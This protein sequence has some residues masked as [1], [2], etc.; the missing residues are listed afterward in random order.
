MKRGFA[1]S[2]CLAAATFAPVTMAGW[3][4]ADPGQVEESKQKPK[5][6]VGSDA[7]ALAV[8]QWVKGEPVEGF[9]PGHVYVVEFWATWCGPCIAGMPHLSELQ[10]RYKGKV[11]I[12][13][14][15]IWDDPKNVAPFM[16]KTGNERMRYTVAIEKKIE[17]QPVNRTGEMDQAWMKAAEQR[18]IPSAFVVDGKGK[19]AFVGH[20][21]WLDVPLE[22]VLAGTWDPE[23]GMKKVA[24][25]EEM[26]GAVYSSSSP[27]ERLAAFD[28]FEAEF[29]GVAH[30]SMFR[31]M[32]F[33]LLVECDKLDRAW[34]LGNEL[35]D[36]GMKTNDTQL[37]NS[38]AWTIVDPDKN[39]KERNLPL[40]LKAA[41]AAAAITE[42]NDAAILDTLARVYWWMGEKSKAVE[43]QR[44]AV[45]KAD[46]RMKG[47]I[48]AV[49]KEYEE[50]MKTDG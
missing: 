44:K 34:A 2:L 40:A 30:Q 47:Q 27:Q 11:T 24:R 28:A 41:K 1:L 19:I 10:E 9:K 50:A 18:G 33:G 45:E 4:H 43:I 8:S 38:V 26:L 49:L 12:I 29:P 3:T 5:L 23:A 25:G 35:V 14:V 15:N 6:W 32:Q 42:E 39:L 48:E 16:E 21:M 22:G 7:P 17:G 37:L 13:G 46:A 31:P 36:E 20:P